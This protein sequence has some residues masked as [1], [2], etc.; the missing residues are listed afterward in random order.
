V[1]ECLGY[2]VLG[3]GVAGAGVVGGVVAGVLGAA[4]S[5]T[6][7]FFSELGAGATGVGAGVLS[8]L[9]STDAGAPGRADA[10]CSTNARNRKI[11]P[12]VQLVFV[13]RLP[14][15]RVPMSESAADVAPPKLAAS[16][17]PFPAW[18]R[19]ATTSTRLSRMSRMMRNV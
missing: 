14:A 7:G 4:S 17:P 3:A 19:I 10:I 2:G 6:A 13:R 12:H 16:P 1:R 8:D 18:R 11:P 5:G 9:S 15:C